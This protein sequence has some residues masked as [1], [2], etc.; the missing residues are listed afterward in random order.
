MVILFIKQK[1]DPD[2]V[3][4]IV[5]NSFKQNFLVQKTLFIQT[6]GDYLKDKVSKS[7][8]QIYVEWTTFKLITVLR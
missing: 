8:S 6:L 1:K 3:N 5:T 4:G 2:Q 7:I